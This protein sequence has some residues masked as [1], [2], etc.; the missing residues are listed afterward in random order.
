MV[1][2]KTRDKGLFSVKCDD[3][4]YV[5]SWHMVWYYC[6]TGTYVASYHHSVAM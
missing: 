4:L 5:S 3:F 6:G 2:S 1:G